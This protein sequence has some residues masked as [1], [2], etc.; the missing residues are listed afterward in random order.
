MADYNLPPKERV[1]AWQK[2]KI[3]MIVLVAISLFGWV[4]WDIEIEWARIIDRMLKNIGVIIPQLL[5]P[6]WS[7]IN[8]VLVKILETV[9]IAFS[10]TLM[11]SII[12]IP[13]GL[14][15]SKTLTSKYVAFLF[16]FSF[17]VNRSFPELIL[18][19]LFVVAVGPNAF[20]GVLAI[21]VHSTGMLGKFYAEAIELIDKSMIEAM[22]ANGASKIQILIH[23]VL[24]QV[25]HELLSLAIYRF[26]INVRSSTVLGIVGAG[27]VGTMIVFAS[28]NR[29]WSEM[30]LIIFLVIIV[31]LL[32]DNLSIMIRKKLL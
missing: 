17:S 30:G 31:V 29:N 5:K 20:A 4:L 26:E 18:A 7:L 22:K 11:A 1:S 8:K 27:G 16:K 25:K 6:E 2:I 10:G 9:L 21:T 15:A 14:F 12:A 23:G 28:M 32:I 13:L 24:P 19:I 3:T